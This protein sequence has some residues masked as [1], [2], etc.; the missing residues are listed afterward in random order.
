MAYLRTPTGLADGFG[1]GSRRGGIALHPTVEDGSPVP[2][3]AGTRLAGR[4]TVRQR[5]L[6][7]PNPFYGAFDL[8]GGSSPKSPEWCC[9]TGEHAS[10]FSM[11][12]SDGIGPAAVSGRPPCV[13]S[14]PKD[15]GGRY[16]EDSVAQTESE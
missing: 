11:A 4:L 6:Q 14:T 1:V 5:G 8:A 7:L 9:S 15:G 12:D 13:A 3:G 16:E 10:R 2:D